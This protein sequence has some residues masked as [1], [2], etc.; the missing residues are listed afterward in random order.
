[1]SSNPIYVKVWCR[2][3]TYRLEVTSMYRPPSTGINRPR[4]PSPLARCESFVTTYYAPSLRSEH[5]SEI[6]NKTKYS[7]V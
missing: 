6:N 3:P 4:V 7:I 2:P 1:M 5:N